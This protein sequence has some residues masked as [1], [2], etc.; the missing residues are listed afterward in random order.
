MEGLSL[1]GKLTPED[2]KIEASRLGS[3]QSKV[4]NTS[5]AKGI[6]DDDGS[7]KRKDS[8]P[9]AFEDSVILE[10]ENEELPHKADRESINEFKN[11][12]YTIKFNKHTE[13]VEL[14]NLDSGNVMQTIKPYELIDLISGLKQ[15]SGLFVDNEI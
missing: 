10:L 6:K 9:E 5:A 1:P 12:A 14:V 7:R 13:L 3:F 4:E 2:P 15:S 8:E 11:A